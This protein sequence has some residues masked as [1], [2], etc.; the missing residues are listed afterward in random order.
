MLKSIIHY[1]VSR[2]FVVIAIILGIAAYGVYAYIQTPVEAYP[3]VTNLQVNV[4]AQKPGLPPPE[5]ERQITIP[6]ERAL[7][8]LQQVIQIRSESLFGLS[9]IYLTFD[10]DADP[11]RARALVSE[12][13]STAELP[14][15]VVPVLGPNTTPLGRIYEYQVISDR[16]TLEELRSEQEWV[17]APMLMRVQGVGDVVSRGGFLKEIHV[18]VDPGRLRAYGLSLQDV[19]EAISKANVNVGGGLFE[20]G[21]QYMVIRGVGYFADAD[22]IKEVVL[23]AKDGT[24]VTVGDIGRVIISH[25]PRQG[26]FGVDENT[27]A[28]QGRAFL[29]RDENPSV[30]LAEI[31]EQVHRINTE[32]LPEGMQIIPLY[33][34]SDLVNL[35]LRTVHM[36]LLMGALLVLGVVWLFIRTLRGSLV[37][38]TVL[39]LSLVAAFIGLYFMGLPANLI[40]MGAIDF[41]ILVDGAVVLVENVIQRSRK[42]KPKKFSERFKL[43]VSAGVDVARPVFFAM[44]ITIASLIPVFTL[45]RVEGRI[46]KPLAMTYTFALLG[47]LV[48]ALTLVPA[49][50]LVFVKGKALVNKEPKWVLSMQRGYSRS[51]GWLL[52]HRWVAFAAGFLLLAGGGFG[53]SRL[54]TEFL[55]QLDE[56]DVLVFVEMPPSISMDKGKEILLEVRQRL[57][58][59]PEVLFVTSQQGRPEDG[60][61][62]EGINMGQVL[63]RLKPR[64]G[65]RRGLT[66]PELEGEMRASLAEIPGVRFNF[67]QPIR[68]SVE[69]AISGV[70]GQVVLKVFGRDLL[71]MRSILQEAREAVHDIPGVVD[72][73]LYRDRRV[74]QLDITTDRSAVA[75]AGIGVDVVQEVI[76]TA[77][78]GKVVSELWEGERIVPIRVRLPRSELEDEARIGEIP[79]SDPSGVVYPLKYLASI[80]TTPGWAAIYREFN[81]RMLALKF[82]IEGRDMGS[83]VRDAI[84]AVNKRVELP[85]GYYLEWGGEFENQQRAMKRL[86]V[87]VPLALLAVISLLLLG[88]GSVR[89]A[90]AVVLVIPFGLTGGVFALL[91]TGVHASISAAIGFVTLLG[92]VC[93][94]ALLVVGAVEENRKQGKPLFEAIRIGTTKRLRV[95]VMALLLTM[96]GLLP[97]AVNTGMGSETQRPFALVIIGGVVTI[98]AVAL[99][100][101]PVMY[102]FIAGKT[103]VGVSKEEEDP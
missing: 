6:L 92:Q 67:S 74:P 15:D 4:I 53:A 14:D 49:L 55:P 69:E 17:I 65:W 64:S 85:D 50:T 91:A 51:L 93:L 80:Q 63:V 81:S 66:K 59:F 46:F 102:S 61:D 20:R 57:K 99:F 31:Q 30:V 32:V 82:N 22:E 36:N 8:G 5:I 7:N 52:K 79:V 39:P 94:M 68:D 21:E 26:T 41:G 60:T 101:L 38:V 1:C 54:G 87:V 48:G 70:R 43:V 62:N 28:V 78:A 56:G 10:D 19:S 103:P 42:E 3:D 18:E 97:M 100:L 29:L 83:V 35:T 13:I 34:R 89:S 40:S 75:R 73:D 45:D 44:S 23:K 24:P 16:H 27:E 88:L 33:D 90:L 25:T 84:A 95:F 12:R 72:L 77:L 9:L 71:L 47:A 76:E 96:L 86:S 2:R 37:I 98:L 58:N 11:F